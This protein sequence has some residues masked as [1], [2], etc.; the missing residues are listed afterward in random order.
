[1]FD[2]AIG[3]GASQHAKQRIYKI[4]AQRDMPFGGPSELHANRSGARDEDTI[5]PNTYQN[6]VPYLPDP[7]CLSAAFYNQVREVDFKMPFD[8]PANG[9]VLDTNL[10]PDMLSDQLE[11]RPNWYDARPFRLQMGQSPNGQVHVTKD[12]ATRVITFELPKGEILKLNLSSYFSLAELDLLGVWQWI[13]EAA[14]TNADQDAALDGRN[15]MLSPWG[16]LTLVHAI[17]QPLFAPD[18]SLD[19]S[20]RSFDATSVGLSYG[21]ELHTASTQELELLAYREDQIDDLAGEYPNITPQD[22][23]SVRTVSETVD[24]RVIAY[25]EVYKIGK[26]ALDYQHVHH[27]GDTKYHRVTYKLRGRTRFEEFFEGRGLSGDDFTRDSFDITLDIPS[28]RRPDPVKV[29]QVLPAF[30][31]DQDKISENKVRKVRKG[32]IRVYAE[33]PWFSSGNNELLGVVHD[34]NPNSHPGEGNSRKIAGLV[35]LIGKDPIHASAPVDSESMLSLQG[36]ESLSSVARLASNTDAE[37]A[38][39]GY[40][41]Q[42]DPERELW[43]ADI[44]IG[45]HGNTYFPFVK[46]ALCRFQPRSVSNS[47]GVDLTTSGVVTTDWTQYPARRTLDVEFQGI[48]DNKYRFEVELFG[49]GFKEESMPSR[50]L[51]SLQQSDPMVADDTLRWSNVEGATYEVHRISDW[52]ETDKVWKGLVEIPLSKILPGDQQYRLMVVEQEKFETG[53]REY[54][55]HIPSVHRLV[56]ACAMS[57]AELGL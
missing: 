22:G 11:N 35:T 9:Q 15:W 45:A 34:P 2:E 42:W 48:Y 44:S 14:G 8:P 7:M 28:T 47:Q 46:L 30:H 6:I 24:T 57:F 27:F 13:K 23:I 43:Y 51:V 1:M 26:T 54:L 41:V 56:Y 38:V 33:R 40:K 12:D 25:P 31:W 55:T 50:V 29:V 4:M 52:D 3:A 20:Q 32:R 21:T 18:F 17:Q 39:A 36:Y 5:F 37:I 16:E 19:P 49:P 53:Y 10:S